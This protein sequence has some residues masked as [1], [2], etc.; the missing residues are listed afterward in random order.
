MNLKELK[1]MVVEEYN[2]YMEQVGP[3][4]EMPVPGAPPI[5]PTGPQIDVQP[6]DI[7]VDAGA[8]EG[9]ILM[10]IFNMLKNHFEGEEAGEMPGGP[11]GPNMA[12]PIPPDGPDGP[13]GGSPTPDV[14]PAGDDGDIGDVE[15]DE[16]MVDIDDEEEGEEE[17]DEWTGKND[18]KAK[19]T[20]GGQYGPK[21]YK[22]ASKSSNGKYGTG[23]KQVNSKGLH[24]IKESK[25]SREASYVARFKKL[26]NINK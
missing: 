24:T 8:D 16:D 13:E 5:P 12:P 11:M 9:E 22:K 4:A 23:M 15:D 2:R 25:E 20:R 21:D 1:Q 3:G 10:N 26:A 6:G 17:L 19:T 7:E 14:E 18:P